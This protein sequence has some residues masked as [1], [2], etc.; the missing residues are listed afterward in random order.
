[1]PLRRYLQPLPHKAAVRKNGPR[2]NS[3]P[4]VLQDCI[5][6][7]VNKMCTVYSVYRQ[8][9]TAVDSHGIN[10]ATTLIAHAALDAI[11]INRQ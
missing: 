1:M 7:I 4:S 5:F 10:H 2:L 8:R 6:S 9:K 3:R 11:V